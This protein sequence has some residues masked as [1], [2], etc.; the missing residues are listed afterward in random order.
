MQ[1]TPRQVGKW[2]AQVDE[3]H[4][5][6]RGWTGNPLQ[7]VQMSTFEWADHQRR[8]STLYSDISRDAIS[9]ASETDL[10]ATLLTGTR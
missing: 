4:D 7:A 8:R 1:L 3:L 9:V 5:L 6:V 2:I 10:V